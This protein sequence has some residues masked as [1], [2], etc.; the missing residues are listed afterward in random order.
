MDPAYVQQMMQAIVAFEM[1][2]IAVEHVFKLSQ[3]RDEKSCENIITHLREGIR[4]HRRLRGS[5]RKKERL[6]SRRGS[7]RS[8]FNKML[9]FA[10]TDFMTRQHSSARFC[11][12]R[13]YLCVG[14]DTDPVRIPAFL[15]S[16]ADPV[17]E[18]N[19]RIIDATRAIV[20]HIKS[21]RHFMK[22]GCRRMGEPAKNG[23]IY[24]LHSFQ[25]SRCKTWGYREYF[26]A[27]C[28]SF[29]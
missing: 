4:A 21:I 23:R 7:G 17:F 28:P 18:F 12:K 29:F 6:I 11:Q 14:L 22:P 3:N 1:E 26:R 13:N 25:N 19:K 15:Q 24:S 9:F 10:E 2:V 5:W 8:V 16:F 20:L 27:I